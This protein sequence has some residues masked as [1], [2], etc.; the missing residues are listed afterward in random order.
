ML[1]YR[2]VK[3]VADGVISQTGERNPALKNSLK[4]KNPI[5]ILNPAE[6]SEST[7]KTRNVAPLVIEYVP[8]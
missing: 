3:G 4:A 8:T 2:K 6:G 5:L 1:D 7:R